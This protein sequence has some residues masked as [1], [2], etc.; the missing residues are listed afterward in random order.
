ML[1]EKITSRQNPLVKRFRRVRS[2]AE[3]HLVLL[4]GVRLVEEALDSG[5]HFET[6]AFT[7]DLESTDRG[8]ALKDALQRVPCRGA[9]LNKQVMDYLSDTES[10]QGIAAL[11]VRPHFTLES[12]F[13]R[14]PQ[15]LIIADGLQDPGNIGAIIRTAEAAGATGLLATT[16]TVSP[17]SPKAL[18]AS[19]GSALRLPIATSQAPEA[20]LNACSESGVTILASNPA[21]PESPRPNS[22]IYTDAD[23]R[24]GVAIVLGS[25]GGGIP[26]RALADA[27]RFVHIPMTP[28]VESLN[29]ASS[30]AIL[31]YEAARQ[32]NF[33]FP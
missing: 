17:Y 20:I 3:P 11:I 21:R 4:E 6:I 28:S 2:G 27:G 22:V 32:R 30:T 5:A 10:P 12:V 33:V 7:A 16:G 13:E 14:E 19:M 9:E 1:V 8:L 26:S 18:R 23:F 15:L 31:L 29:V 25:E 24:Q